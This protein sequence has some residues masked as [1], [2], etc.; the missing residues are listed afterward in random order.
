[1]IIA[2]NRRAASHPWV[3]Q[4][5][6]PALS[7]LGFLLCAV[8]GLVGCN[9]PISSEYRE[10]ARTA[11]SFPQALANPDPYAGTTVVWGGMIVQTSSHVADTDIIVLQSPLDANGEPGAM[12]VSEGRFIAR[13]PGFLDP[14]VYSTGR[15][16]TVAGTIV[17]RE[18]LPVGSAKYSYPV[19]RVK[20]LHLWGPE[21]PEPY[22]DGYWPCYDYYYGPYVGSWYFYGF[23]PHVHLNFGDHGG[24]HGGMH[25]GDHGGGGNHDGGG[26]GGGGHH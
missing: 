5:A 9:N 7:L 21:Y 3:T 22:Y 24:F 25:G 10:E 17:G 2:T 1:M 19:V 11:P 20:Q 26:H 16:I 6:F 8:A 15:A 12:H 18:V 13:N 14:A 4:R 23:S